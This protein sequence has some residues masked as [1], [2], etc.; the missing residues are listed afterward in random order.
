MNGEDLPSRLE[1]PEPPSI[2]LTVA[3][4]A[5]PKPLPLP[6][7]C[8]GGLSIPDVCSAT[9]RRF[10]LLPLGVQPGLDI[11]VRLRGPVGLPALDP[12]R[13]IGLTG[14]SGNGRT[15]GFPPVE[16]EGEGFED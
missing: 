12:S 11:G 9:S 3:I 6:L 7:P 16:D 8:R 13:D 2:L 4:G 15:I 14:R 5:D 1:L 10:V